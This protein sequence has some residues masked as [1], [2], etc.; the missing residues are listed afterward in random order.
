MRGISSDVTAREAQLPGTK[1]GAARSNA[2]GTAVAKDQVPATPAKSEAPR[3]ETTSRLLA[4]KRRREKR[5][6]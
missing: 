5:N 4:A 6:G 3:E 2:A 1:P